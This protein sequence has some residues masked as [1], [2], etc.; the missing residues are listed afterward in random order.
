MMNLVKIKDTTYVRDMQTNAVLNV[1][2]KEINEFNEKRQKILSDR[3]EKEET[4][5]RLAKLESDMSEI[6]KLLI[7]IVQLRSN[8]GN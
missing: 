2:A 8:N 1:N 3:K 5:L 6:K 4:K 7:E